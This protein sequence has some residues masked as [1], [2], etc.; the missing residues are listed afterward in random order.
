[1]TIQNSS[2]DDVGDILYLYDEAVK[3]QKIKCAAPFPNLAASL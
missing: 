2:K 1:M 3:L